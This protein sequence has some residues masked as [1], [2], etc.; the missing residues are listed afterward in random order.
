MG[1]KSGRNGGSSQREALGYIHT[2]A[3]SQWSCGF[4][5]LKGYLMVKM[6][7]DS[8]MPESVESKIRRR[9]VQ[10]LKDLLEAIMDVGISDLRMSGRMIANRG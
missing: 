9:K 10:R 7:G 4:T 6:K 1:F 5:V 8:R 2:A 3:L